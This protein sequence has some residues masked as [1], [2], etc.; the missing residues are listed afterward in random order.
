MRLTHASTTTHTH[1][2]LFFYSVHR[3]HFM[4]RPASGPVESVPQRL[5]TSHIDTELVNRPKPSE[6]CKPGR[7]TAV[8]E[9][10]SCIRPARSPPFA[11]VARMESGRL[12]APVIQTT[13]CEDPTYRWGREHT[14]SKVTPITIILTFMSETP[15]EQVRGSDLPSSLQVSSPGPPLSTHPSSPQRAAFVVA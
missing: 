9:R 1:Q 5:F 7:R 6:S 8:P 12:V 2:N 3:R 15:N 13:F 11:Q 4:L 14:S 10:P